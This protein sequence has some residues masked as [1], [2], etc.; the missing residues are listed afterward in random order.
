MTKKD[1]INFDYTEEVKNV[2]QL[3]MLLEKM[4]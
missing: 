1:D 2:K 4:V 3:M